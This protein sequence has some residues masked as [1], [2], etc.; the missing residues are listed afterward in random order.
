MLNVLGHWYNT[1][2]NIWKDIF[3]DSFPK[4]SLRLYKV[5]DNLYDLYEFVVYCNENSYAWKYC[6]ENNIPHKHMEEK[7]N[8]C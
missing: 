7:S 5:E 6:E 3:I 4:G 8:D 2:T 1:V